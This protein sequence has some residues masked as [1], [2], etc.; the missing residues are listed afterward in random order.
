MACDRQAASPRACARVTR[1]RRVV[2]PTVSDPLAASPTACARATRNH[3]AASRRADVRRRAAACSTIDVRRDPS[4]A[5]GRPTACGLRTTP[6]RV[7]FPTAF[8]RQS[9]SGRAADRHTVAALPSPIDRR[10]DRRAARRAVQPGVA[11]DRPRCGVR[12]DATCLDRHR[13]AADRPVDLSA[14]NR[15]R[16]DRRRGR[17]PLAGRR[18]VAADRMA[19]A[20]STRPLVCRV[21]VH[22]HHADAIRRGG[23]GRHAAGVPHEPG[24]LHAARVPHADHVPREDHVPRAD[25]ARRRWLAFVARRRLDLVTQRVAVRR[26]ERL[27][28]RRARLALRLS[29]LPTAANVLLEALPFCL[30][31]VLVRLSRIA[32]LSARPPLPIA[33]LTVSDRLERPRVRPRAIPTVGR[34]R[35]TS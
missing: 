29:I 32:M 9:L 33:P 25:H 31:R 6:R 20:R 4:R 7:V 34:A 28:I 11:V 1:S 19:G 13:G 17:D 3:R 30:L 35:T 16:G 27:R 26:G 14:A 22:A 12:R 8:D 21:Q 18:L 23:H 15:S 5:A 2:F 10:V 24:D